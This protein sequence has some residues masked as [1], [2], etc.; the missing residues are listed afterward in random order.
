LNPPHPL[1]NMKFTGA[2]VLS[3][4]FFLTYFSGLVAAIDCKQKILV[5]R[6]EFDLSKL[7]SI[8]SVYS[9]DEDK[10][11]AVS[12][13]T[14]NVNICRPLPID[15]E[16]PKKDQCEHGTNGKRCRDPLDHQSDVHSLRNKEN[17]EPGRRPR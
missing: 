10:P 13:T 7:D 1:S 14:W 5:D 8:H 16:Q 9:L 2:S 3:I 11:P 12:N 15:K 17:L 6:R 4:P